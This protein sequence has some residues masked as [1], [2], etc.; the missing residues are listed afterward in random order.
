LETDAGTIAYLFDLS[1]ETIS[2]DAPLTNA[3]G[4]AAFG[5]LLPSHQPDIESIVVQSATVAQVRRLLAQLPPRE[6]EIVARRYGVGGTPETLESIGRSLNLTRERVRQIQVK[7]ERR[8]RA[9]ARRDDPT[10]FPPE[11]V[12]DE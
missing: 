5:A 6:R 11:A 8:L 7:A 1:R 9:L 3:G 12:G 4:A 2:L 10:L